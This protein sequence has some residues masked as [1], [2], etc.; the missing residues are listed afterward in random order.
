MDGIV[1]FLTSTKCIE[2]IEKAA[3]QAAFE[4]VLIFTP[5]VLT[6]YFKYLLSDFSR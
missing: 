4:F 3:P 1:N 5:V 2:N 6:Q